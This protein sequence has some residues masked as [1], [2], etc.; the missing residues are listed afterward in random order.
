[1]ET[2][3][4]GAQKALPLQDDVGFPEEISIIEH[5]EG[6]HV[7]ASEK[8]EVGVLAYGSTSA[9]LLIFSFNHK[10][11]ARAGN[12]FPVLLFKE[13]YQRFYLLINIWDLRFLTGSMY[14]HMVKSKQYKSIYTAHKI[15]LPSDPRP[16]PGTTTLKSSHFVALA[17]W[18]GCSIG[19]YTKKLWV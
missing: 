18:L 6:G 12:M 7:L 14:L 8:F 3:A 17:R 13:K 2:Q 11:A 5:L 4:L 16:S 15:G 9:I 10:M 19:P 1:M